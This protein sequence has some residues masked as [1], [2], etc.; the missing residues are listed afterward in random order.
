MQFLAAGT[1]QNLCFVSSDWFELDDW[2]MRVGGWRYGKYF[3][4]FEGR[5]LASQVYSNPCS[6]D[7]VHWHQQGLPHHPLGWQLSTI[8][9]LLERYFHFESLKYDLHIL[10]QPQVCLNW[11]LQ[12]HRNL[13][14]HLRF[15]TRFAKLCGRAHYLQNLVGTPSHS[16]LSWSRFFD[17]D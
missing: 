10:H 11:H 2:W 8:I 6:N 16:F 14:N 7:V 13:R 1:I 15:P 3:G 4:S 17:Y 5:E 12:H 9:H